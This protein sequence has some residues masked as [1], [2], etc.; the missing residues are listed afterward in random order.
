MKAKTRVMRAGRFSDD[1]VTLGGGRWLHWM[2]GVASSRRQISLM[3]YTD[4]L[5]IKFAVLC[6]LAFI[7]GFIGLLK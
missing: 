1:Y 4:Y 3:E 2:A 7:A 5:L 6:G